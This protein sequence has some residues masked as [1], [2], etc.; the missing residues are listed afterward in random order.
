MSKTKTKPEAKPAEKPIT[1]ALF[2]AC[3]ERLRSTRFPERPMSRDE[4]GRLLDCTG[5]TVMTYESE[6]AAFQRPIP[7]LKSD[8][9]LRL[10]ADRGLAV[11]RVPKSKPATAAKAPEVTP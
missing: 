8:A 5:H 9:L 7:R 2:K 10:L 6:G 11:P 3:R 4:L 1:A